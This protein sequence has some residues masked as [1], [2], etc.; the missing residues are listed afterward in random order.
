MLDRK[1]GYPL[2]YAED[3]YFK[4]KEENMDEFIYEARSLYTLLVAKSQS[5]SFDIDEVKDHVRALE[6]KIKETYE[7]QEVCNIAFPKSSYDWYLSKLVEVEKAIR[8]I[9][10]QGM[11][12]LIG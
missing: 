3:I 7:Q 2:E 8:D 10:V 1:W 5:Y 4:A 11:L 12:D 9:Q 6:Y